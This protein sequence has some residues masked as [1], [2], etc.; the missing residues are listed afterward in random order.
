MR[1]RRSSLLTAL[2]IGLG[3]GVTYPVVDLGLACRA[4]TSE[5]CVWGRAY[6]P[7]TLGVSV[8]LLGGVVAALLYAVL[9]RKRRPSRVMIPSNRAFVGG[10]ADTQRPFSLHLWRRAAQRERSAD[11]R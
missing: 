5:A 11:M 8:V 9:M 7:L 4:P 1:N 6:L 2:A 3:V 10:R